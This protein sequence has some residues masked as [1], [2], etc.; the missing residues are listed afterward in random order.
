MF[1]NRMARENLLDQ[2]R[3]IN[4]AI[5]AR[6]PSEAR[7]AVDRHMSYVQQAMTEQVKSNQNE[8]IAKQRLQHE[9]TR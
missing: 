1:H 6:N 3:A 4:A 8:A 7:A 2:H 5:Q 9:K